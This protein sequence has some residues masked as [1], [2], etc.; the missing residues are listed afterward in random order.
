M[1]T[2]PSSRR[3][4]SEKL[5]SSPHLAVLADQG[6]SGA[7]RRLLLQQ[8]WRGRPPQLL[9]TA[10]SAGLPKHRAR[11]P[12]QGPAPRWPL[13]PVAAT[14]RLSLTAA[15]AASSGSGSIARPHPLWA[16]RRLEHPPHL[17]AGVMGR[18]SQA[19][20]SAGSWRV[21][22][23]DRVAARRPRMP[24]RA[25]ELVECRRSLP[26]DAGYASS[27]RRLIACAART[28][29]ASAV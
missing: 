8:L 3:W 11:A 28:P 21:F 23:L 1:T 25:P 17:R 4:M 27:R 18:R 16:T 29:A 26:R 10:A 24:V 9:E 12:A 13:Q 19:N 20:P 14:A 15:G 22:A 6:G 2:A 7:Q 5:L